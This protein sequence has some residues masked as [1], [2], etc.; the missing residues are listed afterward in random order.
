MDTHSDSQLLNTLTRARV[1]ADQ[2]SKAAMQ[3][4][5]REL[6]LA[7]E[8]QDRILAIRGHAGAESRSAA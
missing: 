7:A 1:E 6:S 4:A 5:A 2:R 8:L 3:E